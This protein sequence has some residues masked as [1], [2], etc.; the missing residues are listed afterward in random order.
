MLKGRFAQRPALRWN[1]RPACGGRQSRRVLSEQFFL[2]CMMFII[3]LTDYLQGGLSESIDLCRIKSYGPRLAPS[4]HHGV[5]HAGDYEDFFLGDTQQVVVVGSA[6]NDAS[7]SEIQIRRLID[8]HRRVSGP[9]TTARLPLLR[10]ARATA[11]PPVTQINDTER[12]LNNCCADSKVG[13][14]MSE[15]K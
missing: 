8:H 15:I 4:R 13:S 6:L 9:A 1:N 5:K 10:A 2:G 11:G 14:Q 12:C 3:A 7:S